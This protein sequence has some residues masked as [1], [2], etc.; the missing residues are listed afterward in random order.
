MHIKTYRRIMYA[1]M[2]L[3]VLSAV[4]ITIFEIIFGSGGLAGISALAFFVFIV[5]FMI[6]YFA[7]RKELEGRK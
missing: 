7:R 6:M 1:L 2:I 5:P 3:A 4:L